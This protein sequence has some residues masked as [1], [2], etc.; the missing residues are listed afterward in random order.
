MVNTTLFTAETHFGH[1]AVLGHR[2]GL[3][4]PFPDI[5][6]HDEALIAAWNAIVR[7]GDTIWHLGDFCHRCSEERAQEIF[8]RLRGRKFLM[9]GN[10]D[11]IGQRLS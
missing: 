2:L 7:P 9:R 1:Q 5:E 6:A 8:S 4:R 11:K 10:H 3:A